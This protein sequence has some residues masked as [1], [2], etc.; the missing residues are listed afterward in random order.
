VVRKLREQ[1][2]KSPT[3]AG[4]L[5]ATPSPWKEEHTAV[6]SHSNFNSWGQLRL[7]AYPLHHGTEEAV[8]SGHH[9]SRKIAGVSSTA[10]C[11]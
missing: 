5:E 9:K 8:R 6:S 11:V 7:V 4:V 3:W 2:I 1:G 10:A